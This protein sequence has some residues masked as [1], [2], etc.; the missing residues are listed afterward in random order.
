MRVLVSCSFD[1]ITSDS[2]DDCACL[3]IIFVA[4]YNLSYPPGSN[5][6]VLLVH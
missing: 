5:K 4:S 3:Q 6:S 2:A 1:D